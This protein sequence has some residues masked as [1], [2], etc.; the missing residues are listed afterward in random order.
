VITPEN[1]TELPSVVIPHVNSP[2]H[3]TPSR[4]LT[5][6]AGLL[7]YGALLIAFAYIGLYLVLAW[8][9]ARYP[10]DLE[11]MEGGSVEHV[12]RLLVGQ[13]LYVAPS[14]DFIPYP[15]PPFYYYVSAVAARLFGLTVGTLRLVS[16]TASLISFST[17]FFLVKRETNDVFAASM[18]TGLFAATF[19]IGGAWFDIARVDSLFLM[20]MLV[21]LYIV[22][23]HGTYPA[24][25]SAG[26]LFSLAI[27]TKQTA[28]V[29]TSALICGLAI[30]DLRKALIVVVVVGVAAGGATLAAQDASGGWYKYYVFDH[31]RQFALKI[32]RSNIA[33]FWSEDMLSHLGIA[34]GLA[35][36][37]IAGV[38]ALSRRRGLFYFLVTSGMLLGA[39]LPRI[40]SAAYEN[41]LMPAHAAICISCGIGLHQV[42]RYS[43]RWPR[44]DGVVVAV[45]VYSL[46]LLQFGALYY[47]PRKQIPTDRDVS[48]GRALVSRLEQIEGRLY[49]PYHV[50]CYV[51]ELFERCRS[52]HQMTMQ[53]IFRY[54]SDEAR[55]SLE[56]DYRKALEEGR[57]ST[58]VMDVAGNS[59]QPEFE[60][61]YEKQQLEL[62]DPFALWTLT[63]YRTRPAFI[64][65]TKPNRG[66]P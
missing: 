36:A 4:G 22:R 57:Y 61:R 64:F 23:F 49:M 26:L 39:W 47:S 37:G 19:R 66:E 24:L 20:L 54:G 33:S 18:A 63:G 25:V 29:M 32:V 59:F 7:K 55:M 46:C 58:V 51:P 43:R 2:D 35:V 16:I 14:L 53:D 13:Q 30:M 34:F 11:W 6:L 10:F 3:L 45:A 12:R 65:L 28:L 31:P 1:S 56:A 40:Q 9:R 50:G 48:A 62:G 52:A 38:A 21:G 8:L 5:R 17:M 44:H 42:M 27:L 60:R 41:T 15:Y